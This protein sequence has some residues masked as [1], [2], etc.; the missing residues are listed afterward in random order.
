MANIQAPHF[1]LLDVPFVSYEDDLVFYDDE[2][3]Y[4]Y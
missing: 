2:V 1:Q 4:Y 3:V